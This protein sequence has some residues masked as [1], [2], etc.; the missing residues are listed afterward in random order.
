MIQIE[1]V[2]YIWLAAVLLMLPID[3]VVS[4]LAAALV[5]ELCHICTLLILGGKIRSIRISGSGCVI[6]ST[7]PGYLQSLCS[8][9]AGPAG[10]MA[11]LLFCRKMPQLAVCGFFHGAYNLLPLLP[12][13]GGNACLLILRRVCPLKAE[14]ILL[15][16]GRFVCSVILTGITWCVYAHKLGSIPGVLFVFWIIKLF[17]RKIPCKPS[18][19]GVQ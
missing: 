18:E 9:L 10:S 2:T 12:L 4:V 7:F 13:D 19:I 8:I 6:A 14:R 3:W 5:H 11:M 16:T 15:W 1:P 17:P